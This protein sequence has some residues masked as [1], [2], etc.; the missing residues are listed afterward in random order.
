[1]DGLRSGTLSVREVSGGKEDLR[2]ER[3][4]TTVP[5]EEESG[6]LIG[7]ERMSIARSWRLYSGGGGFSKGQPNSCNRKVKKG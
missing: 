4:E 7:Q 3:M 1:M 5:C 2:W 6:G